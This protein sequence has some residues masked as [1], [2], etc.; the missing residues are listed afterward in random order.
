M[1]FGLLSN[2]AI[3]HGLATTFFQQQITGT[4]TDG[5]GVPLPGASILEKGTTNGV[6]TDFDGN[7]SITV[8]SA[9]AVLVV[10]YIGFLD[11]EIPVGNNSLM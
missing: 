6:Q 2:N 9:E 8:T 1:I 5:D 3:A 11:S 10:S 7:Y 4:V